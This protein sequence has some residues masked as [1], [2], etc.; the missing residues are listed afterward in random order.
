[1]A[2]SKAPADAHNGESS[3]QLTQ[4]V[5]AKCQTVKNA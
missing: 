4:F 3:E 5:L 1:M 2:V